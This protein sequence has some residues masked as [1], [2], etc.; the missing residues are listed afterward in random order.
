MLVLI[1]FLHMPSYI[2]LRRRHAP[3]VNTNVLPSDAEELPLQG[4]LMVS[5]YTYAIEEFQELKNGLWVAHRVMQTVLSGFFLSACLAYLAPGTLRERYGSNGA[6]WVMYALGWITVL[7]AQ[8][9]LTCTPP[10]EPNTYYTEDPWKIDIYTRPFYLILLLIIGGLQIWIPQLDIANFYLCILWVIFPLLWTTGIAPSLRIFLA[11]AFEKAHTVLTAASPTLS[12]KRTALLFLFTT[13]PSIAV[14]CILL[15]C[16]SPLAA[17]CFSA[18]AGCIVA[19]RVWLDWRTVR[20]SRTNDFPHLIAQVRPSIESLYLCI[21]LVILAAVVAAI[22]ETSDDLMEHPATVVLLIL[23][24]LLTSLLITSHELQ[25]VHIPSCLPVLRNPLRSFIGHGDAIRQRIVRNFGILHMLA[26]HC[27]PYAVTG[28]ILAEALEDFGTRSNK[29]YREAWFWAGLMLMR[30]FR[31]AWIGP[32]TAGIVICGVAIV[33]AGVEYGNWW[34]GLN[35]GTRIL[36]VS[37][38]WEAAVRAW[39]KCGFWVMALAGFLFNKKER[40]PQWYLYLLVS[41]IVTPPVI[42]VSSVIDAPMLPV[43]G[44][45]IFWMGFPRPARFWPSL[46]RDYVPSSDSL[47]YSSLLPKLLPKLS[48]QISQ[49]ALPSISP[50]SNMLLIRL[51]SRLLIVRCVEC[52]FEGVMCLIAGVELEPTSCHALEGTEVDNIL[53]GVLTGKDLKLGNSNIWKTLKPKGVVKTDTYI[54]TRTVVTG[55]LDHPSVLRQIPAVFMKALVWCFARKLGP[56]DVKRFAS[57]IPHLNREVI[58]ACMPLFP[59]KWYDFLEFLKAR[60]RHHSVADIKNEMECESQNNSMEAAALLAS[61]CYAVVFGINTPT[62]APS[63]VADLRTLFR[64]YHGDLPSLPSAGRLWLD[65]ADH[66]ELRWIC[67]VSFRWAVRTIYER[68]GEEPQEEEFDDINALFEAYDTVHHTSLDPSSLL[69]NPLPFD[70]ASTPT[71]WRSVL[72]RGGESLFGMYLQADGMRGNTVGVRMIKKERDVC[73]WVGEV[74]GEAVRGIWANLV[75][76]LLYLTNDDDERYSIQAHPLLL[77]NLTVQT[78]NPPLG[79]PLYLGHGAISLPI[80]GTGARRDR[81]VN[82]EG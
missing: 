4:P 19:S 59:A 60:K 48:A 47:L 2:S 29:P 49:G 74:N 65:A 30:A 31:Y 50:S 79:Y 44:L 77:R 71:A 27:L 78:S 56:Q 58:Q 6:A 3:A 42:V 67:L 13:V 63:P 66:S 5:A 72:A 33:D 15:V 69:S 62:A 64:I 35:V 14:T 24:I 10:P 18:I 34:L 1:I 81:R 7:M 70:T 80:W 53:E 68:A 73:C 37:I 55:V 25:Q 51:D 32:G 11:T 43:M 76:E 45:P 9:S 52:Y 12:P 61:V 21:R 57:T 23:V 38:V 41:M 28:W 75:F 17:L 46:D 26:Y 36:I 54:S 39:W 22:G 40:R 16:V 82:I 8:W 20:T